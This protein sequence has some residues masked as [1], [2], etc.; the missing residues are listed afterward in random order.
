MDAFHHGQISLDLDQSAAA[1]TYY[2]GNIHDLSLGSMENIY[3]L[4]EM[5]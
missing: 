2:K 1:V 4:R 5:N 3:I